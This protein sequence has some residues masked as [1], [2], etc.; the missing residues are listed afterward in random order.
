[1]VT[2]TCPPAF[3]AV[4]ISIGI[5]TMQVPYENGAW[6]TRVF[7]F[8]GI[9]DAFWDGDFTYFGVKTGVGLMAGDGIYIKSIELLK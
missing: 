9:D 8:S 4:P 6:N 1:M 2:D 3:P 7:D 5:N